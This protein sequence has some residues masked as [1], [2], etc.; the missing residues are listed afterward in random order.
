MFLSVF[1]NIE[2]HIAQATNLV[3][4]IPTALAINFFNIK[5]KNVDVK[6]GYAI[7]FFG[8]IG[9]LIGSLISVKISS[10]NLRKYFAIFLLFV[11]IREIYIL[12]KDK[13][14]V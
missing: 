13:N 1:Y 9:S 7:I 4:F 5:N 10:S 11:A 12:I 3:Y 8:I 14:K 6:S 2:Q